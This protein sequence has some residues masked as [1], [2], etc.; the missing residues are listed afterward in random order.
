MIVVS[1][2]DLWASASYA[3]PQQKY[4]PRMGRAD[5]K[6]MFGNISKFLG[7]ASDLGI[8]KFKCK[9]K[10]KIGGNLNLKVKVQNMEFFFSREV[11]LSFYLANGS[12]APKSTRL[13]LGTATMPSL[14]GRKGKRVKLKVEIPENVEPGDYVI[15]VEINPDDS[16]VEVNDENNI[17]EREISILN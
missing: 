8:K 3:P 17:S 5:N 2:S 9:G 1:D 10:A 16:P 12:M 6:L 11:S 14:R 15:Q 7:G 4:N 13:K